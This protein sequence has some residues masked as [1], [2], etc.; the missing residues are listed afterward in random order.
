MEIPFQ[1]ITIATFFQFILNENKYDPDISVGNYNSRL[2]SIIL[3]ILAVFRT[4][5]IEELLKEMEL[6]RNMANSM[7]ALSSSFLALFVS[8]YFLYMIYAV[9]GMRLYGGMIN[10]HSIVELNKN[11]GIEILWVY[12]NFNDYASGL[13]TLY[14]VMTLNGWNQMMTMFVYAGQELD[15]RNGPYTFTYFI[16]FILISFYLVLNI[17]VA[18]II[19]SYSQRQDQITLE[20]NLKLKESAELLRIVEEKTKAAEKLQKE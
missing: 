19:D 8:L 7:S 10:K 11:Y 14:G 2:V 20:K 3:S 4:M 18:F 12:V 17:L 1:I 15:S 9:I 6:W 5:R 16:S 13:I